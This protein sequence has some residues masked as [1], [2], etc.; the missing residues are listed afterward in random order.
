VG[1]S[2]DGDGREIFGEERAIGFRVRDT[3][4]AIRIF[5]R[6]ARFDVPDRYDESAGIWDGDPPGLAPRT[7]SAFGS[8]PDRESQVAALLTVRDPDRDPWAPSIAAGGS[9]VLGLRANRLGAVSGRRHYQEARIEPG[10]IVTVVGRALPFGD[11]DDPASADVVDG[12]VDPTGDPEIAAD[13]AEARDA[14]V[15]A[16]SP[17]AAW[18]NAAIEGFG[19]GR[20]VRSPILD[21]DATPEPVAEPALR[22]RADAA[23][24]IASGDLVIAAS[25][26]VPLLIA[27]GAPASAAARQQARFIVGLLGGVLAIGSAVVMALIVDGTIR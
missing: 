13:L 25:D 9:T 26:E 11:L 8:V 15:L 3:S 10:D 17:Q 2:G 19:I 4:G 6:G 12:S 16:A 14:G 20:P 22:V 7:G 21:P 27:L 24:E 18:G 5:P 1:D 23:F